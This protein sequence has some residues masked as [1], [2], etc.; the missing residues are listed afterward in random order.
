[1]ASLQNLRT[2]L[3][4]IIVIHRQRTNKRINDKARGNK[5]GWPILIS[6]SQG[7]KENLGQINLTLYSNLKKV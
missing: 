5:Y 7:N 1:M 4:Y 6:S 2:A 3:H